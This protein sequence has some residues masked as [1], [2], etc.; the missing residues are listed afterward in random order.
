VDFAV[1]DRDFES[2]RGEIGPQGF[3]N[4]KVIEANFHDLVEGFYRSPSVD[5]D[6]AG[7]QVRIPR[8]FYRDLGIMQDEI[9][10]D[11]SGLREMGAR[12]RARVMRQ[13]TWDAKAAQ[14]FEV[15]RW[16]LG[17]RDR[18][19]FGMPLPDV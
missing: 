6:A 1:L 9:V 11:P 17:R 16:V 15:Y 12:A 7:V 5:L 19:D 8:W 2:A 10:A 4:R 18:P 13:F 3:L 14:T